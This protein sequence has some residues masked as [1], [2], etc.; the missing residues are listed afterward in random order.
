MLE[1]RRILCDTPLTCVPNPSRYC[2]ASLPAVPSRIRFLWTCHG[3]VQFI[4]IISDTSARIPKTSKKTPAQALLDPRLSK[5]MAIFPASRLVHLHTRCT[6]APGLR[7]DHPQNL[8]PSWASCSYLLYHPPFLMSHS[9]STILSLFSLRYGPRF[10]QY[11]SHYTFDSRMPPSNG[12][13]TLLVHKPL[14][15]L[16]HLRLCLKLVVVLTPLMA[17]APGLQLF[18]LVYAF[19]PLSVS[20]PGACAYPTPLRFGTVTASRRR[21]S[22]AP[23]LFPLLTYPLLVTWSACIM[24]IDSY[25]LG[26]C[27]RASSR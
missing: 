20:F 24:E 16:I 27:L 22:L 2:P 26:K 11:R 9:Y 8:D 3:H 13:V 1:H 14:H 6:A 25:L 4:P 21:G 12:R 15:C 5:T 18:R 23:H 7:P 17:R 10:S 19:S